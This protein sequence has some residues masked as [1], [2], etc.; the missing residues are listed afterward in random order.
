MYINSY[1]AAKLNITIKK[2]TKSKTEA[3][4]KISGE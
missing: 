1:Y 3:K 2:T 4:A